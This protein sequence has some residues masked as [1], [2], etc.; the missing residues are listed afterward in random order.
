MEETSEKIILFGPRNGRDI[1]KLYPEIANDDRFKR[2]SNDE[3]LFAWLMGIPNSPCDESWGDMPRW[4]SAANRAFSGNKEKKDTY[5]TGTFPDEV[6]RA[7]NAFATFSPEA[8]LLAK[9]MVQTAYHNYNSLI[10]ADVEK[11]FLIT[12]V[13]GK[14]DDKETITE[15]DW[16]GRNNYVNSTNNII[17]AL[18]DLLKLM[19]E[20]FGIDEKKKHDETPGSREIEK[21]VSNKSEKSDK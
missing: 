9:R 6:K 8:R 4:K 15:M 16:S 18:P 19:E 10:S 21:Y 12:K 11:D 20:G 3:L 7:I 17:K 2:I 1:R 13:V 5:A 14:G